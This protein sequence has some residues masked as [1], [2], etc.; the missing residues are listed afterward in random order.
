MKNAWDAPASIESLA[1]LRQLDA[2]WRPSLL[3]GLII[4]FDDTVATL[5][6]PHAD[7]M[8]QG[9][10]TAQQYFEAQGMELFPD[11]WE[12]IIEARRFAQQKSDEEAEEHIANDTMSFLL[13]FCGYPASRMDEQVLAAGVDL[14]YA[15][16]MTDWT[17]APRVR[18]T[19]AALQ[20]LGLKLALVANYPCD[21]VFQ[22]SVD[23][24]QVRPLFDVVLCSASVAWRK[25]DAAIF[26]VVLDR[27]QLQPH[28]VAVVGNDLKQDIAGGQALGALTALSQAVAPNGQTAYDNRQAAARVQPDATFQAWPDLVRVVQG[29][30]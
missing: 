14:F 27:W 11:F 17:L 7:L 24:L 29:W 3:S 15:P 23:Y 20:A 13:Q 5:R 26:E 12:Q 19:L 10:R 16:E 22:R 21:R 1:D 4:D 6:T 18:E 28:E 8:A 30:M 2:R 25:P 9:A